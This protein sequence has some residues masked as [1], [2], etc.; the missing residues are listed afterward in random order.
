MVAGEVEI[1]RLNSSSSPEA[2]D[3]RATFS[4]PPLAVDPAGSAI[5]YW[6]R[7]SSKVCKKKER[8]K[9][10]RGV[11]RQREEGEGR[12]ETNLQELSSSPESSDSLSLEIGI[13]HEN[14]VSPLGSLEV[15]SVFLGKESKKKRKNVRLV[16]A[17]RRVDSQEKEKEANSREVSR[18]STTEEYPR[19]P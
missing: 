10:A 16:F 18:S 12:G 9:S 19:E 3:P 13:S 2:E 11:R 8:S 7:T 15:G 4:P 5:P 6:A 1:Y 14:H 17:S